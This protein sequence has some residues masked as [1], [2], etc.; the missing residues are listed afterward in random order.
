MASRKV[1]GAVEP[2]AR[3][4]ELLATKVLAQWWAPMGRDFIIITTVSAVE[5]RGRVGAVRE[6]GQLPE[7][8]LADR[9]TSLTL[10]L[11]EVLEHMKNFGLRHR[12]L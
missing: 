12:V 11:D 4:L 5:L 1:S 7:V 3:Q 10:Q 2:I 8:A 6:S 9:T